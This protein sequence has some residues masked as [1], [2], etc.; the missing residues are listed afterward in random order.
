LPAVCVN[1]E[2]TLG[3]QHVVHTYFGE[4]NPGIFFHKH[5]HGIIAQ[6]YKISSRKKS[7]TIG[8]S[9]NNLGA[10]GNFAAR[11]NR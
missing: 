10:L 6:D 4:N 5:P 7:D 9:I 3:Y 8:H 1:S 11:K 2:K